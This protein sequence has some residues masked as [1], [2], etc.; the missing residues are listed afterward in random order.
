MYKPFN[1][2][3]NNTLEATMHETLL[4]YIQIFIS[5][6]SLGDIYFMVKSS[7]S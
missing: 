1:L 6:V 4:T 2:H 3:Q 5:F 7:D